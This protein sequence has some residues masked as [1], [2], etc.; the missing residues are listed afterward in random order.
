MTPDNDH[1][2]SV[3]LVEDDVDIWEML[4]TVLLDDNIELGWARTGETNGVRFGNS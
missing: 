3:L 2:Y 4:S 1:P